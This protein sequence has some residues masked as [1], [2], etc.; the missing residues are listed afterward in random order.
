MIKK[1]ALYNIN[2]AHIKRI[3]NWLTDRSQKVVVNGES[4]PNEDIQHFHPR[5]GSKYEITAD[6][7]CDDKDRGAETSN[8]GWLGRCPVHQPLGGSSWGP[9]GTRQPWAGGPEQHTSPAWLARGGRHRPAP[10]CAGQ[11]LQGA[12]AWPHTSEQELFMG[13]RGRGSE[14]TVPVVQ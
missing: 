7:T 13:G 2:R 6:T 14:G 9:G 12:A 1:L 3:K 5:S 4:S 10:S 8:G 11:G